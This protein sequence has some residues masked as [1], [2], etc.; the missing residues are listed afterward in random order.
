MDLPKLELVRTPVGF[1]KFGVLK[2]LN[3][4]ARKSSPT[5]SV[6]ENR[7]RTERSTCFRPKP[8][9]VFLPSV[10]CRPCACGVVASNASRLKMKPPGYPSL[11]K[12]RGLPNTRSGR[13]TLVIPERVAPRDH[14]H[15]CGG[16]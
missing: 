11:Y 14:Q 12:Y 7:R 16:P 1:P 4:S 10:P 13:E 6:I 3:A 9:N 8:R 2:I 15:R 5:V